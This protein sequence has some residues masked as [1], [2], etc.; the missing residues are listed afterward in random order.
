MASI[1]SFSSV[2]E[3]DM[4]LVCPDSSCSLALKKDTLFRVMQREALNMQNVLKILSPITQFLSTFSCLPVF[5]FFA[6][7]AI[8]QKV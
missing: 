4:G 6:T 3:E 7:T 1:I 8:V 2:I 5:V